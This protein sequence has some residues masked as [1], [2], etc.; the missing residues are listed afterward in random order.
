MRLGF[1]GGSFDPPHVAHV[2]MARLAL[3]SGHVD[4]V[5]VVP[6][7]AHAFEKRAWASFDDRIALCGLAFAELPQVGVLPIER[8]LASPSYTVQ[9]IRALLSRRP[10]ERMRL[11]VGADVVPELPRWHEADALLK[12]APPLVF[13]RVGTPLPTGAIAGLPAVS[14]TEVR[15]L[16]RKVLTDEPEPGDEARVESLLPLPVLAEIRRRRLYGAEPH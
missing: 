10:A 14:S 4:E 5:V 1:L 6:V 16:L 2:E 9:T 13:A 3:S 12:L 15:T 11:L 7:F 8:E